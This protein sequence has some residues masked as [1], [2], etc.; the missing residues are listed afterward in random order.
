MT[1]HLHQRF[2]ELRDT[3]QHVALGSAP[4]PVHQLSRLTTTDTP[5]W[6]KDDGTY[7]NGGWGGNK[8]R[9][10]E[11][12]LPEVKRQRRNT[13]L[14]FG[15]IGTNWGLAASLYARA[16]G[17][18]TALALINQPVDS[19]VTAQ[20]KRLRA[21]GAD[22][23][24]TRSKSRTIAAA[25]FLYLRHRRPYLLPAG[26]SSPLGTLGYVEMA[27]ELAAQIQGGTMPTPSSIV[28]AVGS[29][30]TVA[31]L[32]LGLALAGLTDTQVIGIVVNDTLRLNHQSITSLARRAARLLR[33]RG[34]NL[35]PIHLRADRL[36]LLRHWLG[37]GYGHPTSGGARALKL[38][39]DTEQLELDSVYTAKAMAALLDLTANGRLPDGPTL[40][41]QT[42]GPR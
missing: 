3:L 40:Y 36:L 39:R 33:N 15:G 31:G 28:T 34:A 6:I 16:C 1:A 37:A 17:I 27:F 11:W 24:L 10:L 42:H 23:Y 30:G 19:H 25:P 8:V 26:G 14:T 2:P 20:L 7:G 35:P 5:V 41:L 32:H 18:H 22:I 21:S 12:L 38:A 4:T 29:G 13:I 9:K